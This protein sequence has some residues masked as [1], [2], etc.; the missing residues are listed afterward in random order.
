MYIKK[1]LGIT[2]FKN[3]SIMTGHNYTD[4]AGNDVENWKAQPL[5]MIKDTLL[6]GVVVSNIL[7]LDG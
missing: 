2:V 4:I 6:T 3:C 1:I 7:C 5:D